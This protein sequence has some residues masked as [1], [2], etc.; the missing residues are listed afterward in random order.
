MGS[1]SSAFERVHFPALRRRRARKRVE[2]NELTL[3]FFPSPPLSSQAAAIVVKKHIKRENVWT[4]DEKGFM[5]GL[6]KQK[7]LLMWR[8]PSKRSEK[9]GTP[10]QFQGELSFVSFPLFPSLCSTPFAR[11]SS[12]R[13]PL[14]NQPFPFSPCGSIDGN[15]ELVTVV[16]CVSAAGA[17]I[18]PLIIMKG[19]YLPF[20][21]ARNSTL[22]TGT[23]FAA[24][25]KGY[26]YSTVALEWMVHFEK[27]TR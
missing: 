9:K 11:S 19:K 4:M 27:G 1:A 14:P 8:D 21:W 3:A 15:R 17:S 5:L 2:S 18:E 23:G 13:Y 12:L 26:I 22:P 20:E 10:K 24:T 16:E 6:S 25:S 7:T